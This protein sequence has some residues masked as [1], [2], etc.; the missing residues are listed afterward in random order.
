MHNSKVVFKRLKRLK[1]I[2]S[3]KPKMPGINGVL[4]F[5]FLDKRAG[6]KDAQK[7]Q[8]CKLGEGHITPHIDDKARMFDSY[9]NKMYLRTALNLE[10]LVTEAHALVVEFNLIASKR[11]RV[12]SG[13]SENDLR[14]A[15]ADAA[16]ALQNEKRKVEI[17]T[18]IAE[19][20]AASDM[21]DESLKHH[22]ERAEGIFRSRISKY[23]KGVLE[24]SGE[25]LEHFPCLEKKDYEGRKE[26][27]HNREKLISML[28][29]AIVKGGGLN[30]EKK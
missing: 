7:N 19:M 9:I 29:D 22:L 12:S 15:A 30:E 13:N 24:T 6:K 2:L 17:L 4:N 20:R 8:I 11:V 10:P 25:K 26:Y 28:D 16:Y 18:L 27:I 23:W 21:I 14:Q 5:R 1:R 3:R